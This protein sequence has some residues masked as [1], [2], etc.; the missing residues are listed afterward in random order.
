MVNRPR[1]RRPLPP[2]KGPDEARALACCAGDP[3]CE[4]ALKDLFA[5]IAD[6]PGMGSLSPDANKCFR[7]C[8]KFLERNF[9]DWQRGQEIKRGNDSI[10][11][12]PK[13]AGTKDGK[14]I[15]TDRFVLGWKMGSMTGHC[16]FEVKIKA[17]TAYFDLGDDTNQGNFG[18]S[19]NWFFPDEPN[20]REQLPIG[21]ENDY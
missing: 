21:N 16:Y 5:K 15:V 4:A 3:A 1:P 2:G 6:M 9:P 12:K 7:W 10:K 18:G 19:D 17:R 20:F 13:E 8:T 11:I 14:E